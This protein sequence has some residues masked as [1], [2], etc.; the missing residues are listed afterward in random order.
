MAAK[1]LIAILESMAKAISSENVRWQLYYISCQ[2][3][4]HML[5]QVAIK[6]VLNSEKIEVKKTH[7]AKCAV[8]SMQKFSSKIEAEVRVLLLTDVARRTDTS[9]AELSQRWDFRTRG[10][11]GARVL[12]ASSSCG[13]QR[14][15]SCDCGQGGLRSNDLWREEES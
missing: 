3:V 11:N 8:V 14:P 13:P 10:Q 1:Q 4:H 2:P 9:S 12:L 15:T 7:L 5:T 6:D